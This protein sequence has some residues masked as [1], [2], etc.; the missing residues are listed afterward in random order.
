MTK[1]PTVGS[2]MVGRQRADHKVLFIM[3]KTD[4]ETQCPKL[5]LRQSAASCLTH[6]WVR[7]CGSICLLQLSATEGD[8]DD[9]NGLC[10]LFD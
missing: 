9:E 3:W 1:S 6:S 5:Q 4:E 2:A 8:F 7:G 10:T